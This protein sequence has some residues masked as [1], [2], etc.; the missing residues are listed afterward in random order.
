LS[1]HGEL[2]GPAALAAGIRAV[3]DASITVIVQ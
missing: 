1:P 2:D 3:F